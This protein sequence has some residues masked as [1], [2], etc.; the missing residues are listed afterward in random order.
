MD[1]T[2]RCCP[3]STSRIIPG[4]VPMNAERARGDSRPHDR[5]GHWLHSSEGR[6]ATDDDGELS[7][8]QLRGFLLQTRTLRY[9]A[10]DPKS[11]PRMQ[12]PLCNWRGDS[13][14]TD[15]ARFL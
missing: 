4:H 10:L 1:T 3:L 6:R 8:Q 15:L 9:P 2:M 11:S 7:D 12:C 13:V 14:T 5:G